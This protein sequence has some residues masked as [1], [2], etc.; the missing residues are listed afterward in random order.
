MQCS[1][2]TDAPRG[3]V[4]LYVNTDAPT[5]LQTGM[6]PFLAEAV[7]DSL[8]V[9]V[10]S[11]D[12]TVLESSDVLAPDDANWPISF[13][14]LG[15]TGLSVARVRLRAFRAHDTELEVIPGTDA[16]QINP[17]PSFTIDRIVEVPVPSDTGILRIEVI[18][19]AACKGSRP[20]FLNRTTCISADQLSGSFRDDLTVIATPPTKRPVWWPDEDRTS[21]A[22]ACTDS[23]CP[24]GAVCI[25]GGQFTLGDRRIVGFGT[26]AR[27]DA[28]PPHPIAMKSFC[29]DAQEMTFERFRPIVASAKLS[30]PEGDG[31]AVPPNP[32]DTMPV[33]C[34]G[35]ASAQAACESLMGRLPSE[36]EWEYVAS[37]LGRGSLFP[38]G[39]DAPDGTTALLDTSDAFPDS[40][41]QSH[42]DVTQGVWNLGGSVSEWVLDT[43][44]GYGESS[45][46]KNCW[47]RD[48]LRWHPS[49]QLGDGLWSVRGGSFM[50]DRTR[51]YTRIRN[52]VTLPQPYLG[53]RCAY[54]L[55]GKADPL[56]RM[57]GGNR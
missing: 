13:G 17:I 20:N 40:T 3:Q 7:V 49:C 14:L 9:D 2:G 37:G 38:W 23:A 33:T 12:N 54:A 8:R 24:T 19:H 11:E 10:L 53:F 32:T 44:V 16:S 36:S 5:A 55:N 6:H 15:R 51:A 56:Q 4:V 46:G 31:C 34:V 28:V 57:V 35:H 18:L 50:H 30:W 25:P 45:P 26:D 29:L 39:D 1:S 27:S 43:Y 52:A 47:Q 41:N 22:T 21:E 42:R 48:G